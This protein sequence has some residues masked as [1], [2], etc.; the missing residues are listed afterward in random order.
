MAGITKITAGKG[1]IGIY[2]EG[3]SQVSNVD[4]SKI[5]VGT[6]GIYLYS[7]VGTSISFTENITADNQIGIVAAGG[8]RCV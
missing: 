2:A 6:D 4:A 7:T 8:S 5:T 1:G 3:T